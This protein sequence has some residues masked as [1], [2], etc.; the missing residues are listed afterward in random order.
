MEIENIK[1]NYYIVKLN[2]KHELNNFSCGLNDMDDFLKNDALSQQEEKLNVTY[3]AMYDKEIIGFFS[4]LSDIIKLKDIEQD[5]DLPYS[6]CPAIK[7]GRF[8]V[9]EKY[10]SSGLGTVLLDNVCYQIKKISEIHGVRF[11]TVDAY[12]N[13]RG[14][15]YRNKFNHFKIHNEN[16]LM[17]A[18]TRNPNLTIPLYKDLKRI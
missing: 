6:T 9:N 15:Y 14:F 1:N 12:C 13:V 5:Y 18:A 17:R 16:K 11:I 10:N 3:L 7:I 2:Q 8:A 4:L